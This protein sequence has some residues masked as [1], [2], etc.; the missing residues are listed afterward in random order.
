MGEHRYEGVKVPTKYRLLLRQ[1]QRGQWS[2]RELEWVRRQ[3]PDLPPLIV[4]V[5]REKLAQ[6]GTSSENG[7]AHHGT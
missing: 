7:G 6:V 3:H 2:Q 5:V 1:L 4:A